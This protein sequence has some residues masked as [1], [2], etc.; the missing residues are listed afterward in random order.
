IYCINQFPIPGLD[1]FSIVTGDAAGEIDVSIDLPADTAEY[2]RVE[3]RRLT[4]AT[5][6][7]DTCSNGSVVHDFVAPYTDTMTW[8]DTG[9]TPGGAYSYRICVYDAEDNVHFP[10]P[11]NA[12]TYQVSNVTAAP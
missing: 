7:N 5:S 3:I 1:T 12:T 4:G 10:Q 8:T 11:Y 6:P 2:G 9:L